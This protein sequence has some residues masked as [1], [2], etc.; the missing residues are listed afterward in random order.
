MAF[1]PQGSASPKAGKSK[2][3]LIDVEKVLMS[4]STDIKWSSS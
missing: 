4:Q 1:C 2:Y 3:V